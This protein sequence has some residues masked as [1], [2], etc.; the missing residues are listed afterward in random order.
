MSAL[1]NC[2]STTAI[3]RVVGGLLLI[4]SLGALGA[5]YAALISI[6]IYNVGTVGYARLRLGLD[7]T[8]LGFKPRSS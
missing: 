5:A 1:L 2:D 6:V 7:V 4:P 3:V 8:P